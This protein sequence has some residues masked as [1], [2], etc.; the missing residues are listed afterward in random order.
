WSANTAFAAEQLQ[1]VIQL[2]AAPYANPVQLGDD[3]QAVQKLY[4]TRGYMAARVHPFAQMD[5]T[6][7]TVAYEL[8]VHEGGVYHKGEL[9]IQGLDARTTARLV[10]GWKLRGGDIYDAS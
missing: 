10:E 5:D 1:P 3:L 8:Q 2:P 9:E 7:S 6:Q 4:G